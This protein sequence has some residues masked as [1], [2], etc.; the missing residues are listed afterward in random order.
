[1]LRSLALLALVACSTSS[2]A[3]MLPLASPMLAEEALGGQEVVDIG[4]TVQ[5]CADTGS[6]TFSLRKRQGVVSV[7]APMSEQDEID[8]IAAAAV[9]RSAFDTEASSILGS[10]F[11]NLPTSSGNDGKALL[12]DMYV[13]KLDACAC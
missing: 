6:C 1:M 2:P 13:S 9:S 10:W 12:F 7:D 5:C 3:P 11:D 4:Y 8:L